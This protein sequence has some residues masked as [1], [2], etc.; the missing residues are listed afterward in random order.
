MGIKRRQFLSVGASWGIGGLL[1]YQHASVAGV[2][3]ELHWDIEKDVLVA[4][5]GAAGCAAAIAASDSGATVMLV[6]KAGAFGGTSAKSGG[7]YWIPNNF[8][9]RARGLVDAKSDFLRFAVRYSY[10]EFYEP[11]APTLG[12]PIRLYSLLEAFYENGSRVI[13]CFARTGALRSDGFAAP[14]TGELF[15]DY[16]A[17]C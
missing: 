8:A 13:D 12:L 9:M 2:A 10:P 11:E 14:G 3:G 17:G 7:A 4:G 1:G 15:Q 5:S 16:L 6:E